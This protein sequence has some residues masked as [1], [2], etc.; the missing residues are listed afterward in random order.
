MKKIYPHITKRRLYLTVPYYKG[1]HENIQRNITKY[2][3]TLINKR[4]KT[5]DNLL[6]NNKTKTKREEE[7]G[8]YQ[9]NC[10]SCPA[11]YI[12]MT[13]RNM[14][15]RF[16]EHSKNHPKSALGCHINECKHNIEFDNLKILHKGHNFYKLTML[17]Q[18]EILKNRDNRHLLNELSDFNLREG[19]LI[20]IINFPN[21]PPNIRNVTDDNLN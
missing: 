20:K 11:F 3:Y 13:T 18:L 2:D 1:L 17:E 15:K 6:V 14:K 16:D 4:H 19:S 9:I 5:I 12:G 21:I 10:S 8:V 7:S